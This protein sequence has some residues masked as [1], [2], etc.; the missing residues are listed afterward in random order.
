MCGKHHSK[1]LI[2]NELLSVMFTLVCFCCVVVMFEKDG[3]A[4]MEMLRTEENKFKLGAA[5]DEYN[6][7]FHLK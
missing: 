5:M 4:A 3:E 6:N 2:I 1:V 7:T